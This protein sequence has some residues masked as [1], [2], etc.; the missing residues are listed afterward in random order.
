MTEPS[1]PLSLEQKEI[2]VSCRVRRVSRR[3]RREFAGWSGASSQ[4]GVG[5]GGALVGVGEE[6]R[7]KRRGAWSMVYEAGADA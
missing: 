7:V 6:K 2:W 1:I 5:H 3:M 4:C